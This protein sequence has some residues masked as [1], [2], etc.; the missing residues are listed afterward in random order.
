MTALP[1][2]SSMLFYVLFFVFNF[3]EI[4][5]HIYIVILFYFSLPQN[6]SKV[7]S[8]PSIVSSSPRTVNFMLPDPRT[9]PFVCGRPMWVRRTASGNAS[10][11][12]WTIPWG[13]TDR[14]WTIWTTAFTRWLQIEGRLEMRPRGKWRGE[15]KDWRERGCWRELNRAGKEILK[16]PAHTV[17]ILTGKVLQSFLSP[18]KTEKILQYWFA[19]Y[20]YIDSVKELYI[21]I[22]SKFFFYCFFF[23]KSWA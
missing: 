14:Q 9:V 20:W 18:H 10:R 16:A 6:R 13:W 2:I 1:T 8:G 11:G 12:A 15:V 17:D 4:I 22:Y 19:L 7:T 21:P 23:F 5:I 3:I